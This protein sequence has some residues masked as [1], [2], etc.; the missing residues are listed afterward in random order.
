MVGLVACSSSG[1]RS[2]P[3]RSPR[4][5]GACA[6]RSS[7]VSGSKWQISSAAAATRASAPGR[8]PAGAARRRRP[9][10]P[11]RTGSAAVVGRRAAAR[12][13][14]RC[15]RAGTRPGSRVF[16][17]ACS[18]ASVRPASSG[19]AELD[20][21]GV[22]AVLDERDHPSAC[23]GSSG[24]RGS[25]SFGCV[26]PRPVAALACRARTRAVPVL[27]PPPPAQVDPPDRRR[28]RR[29]SAWRAASR[30]ASTVAVRTS[31]APSTLGERTPVRMLVAQAQPL[32]LV[33]VD[34][35][36]PLGGDVL[37]PEQVRDRRA[38]RRLA[39]LAEVRAGAVAASGGRSR[40]PRRAWPSG[41]QTRRRRPLDGQDDAVDLVAEPSW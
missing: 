31:A 16:S 19:S 35:V 24:R 30:R 15:P 9:R 4:A 33:A 27:L 21:Q 14:A 12:P 7:P 6:R 23:A 39:A 13:P 11:R 25:S 17:A 37:Q 5:A 22:A 38:E 34:P 41:Q 36:P 28:L 1:S 2:R 40:R 3:P 10:P 32:L 18:E 8:R 20:E 29:R 26:V